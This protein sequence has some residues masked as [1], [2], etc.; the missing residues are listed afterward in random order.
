MIR[1]ERAARFSHAVKAA[2]QSPP[3]ELHK[4]LQGGIIIG[5]KGLPRKHLRPVF[6]PA[7]KKYANSENTALL[8]KVPCPPGPVRAGERAPGRRRHFTVLRS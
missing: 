4:L 3:F 5:S 8:A 2:G 7:A 6:P 1:P